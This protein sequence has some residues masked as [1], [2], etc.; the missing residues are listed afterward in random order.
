[1]PTALVGYGLPALFIL[2]AIKF[3]GRGIMDQKATGFVINYLAPRPLGTIIFDPRLNDFGLYQARELSYLVDY[4][5]A[6]VFSD[7]LD[8]HILSFIPFNG[9]LA[10]IVAAVIYF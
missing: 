5:D 2:H 7:L 3:W 4:I 9:A 6:R 8:R 1:V 10:L